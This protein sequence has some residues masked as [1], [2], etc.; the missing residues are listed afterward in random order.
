[1]K[2]S[3]VISLFLAFAVIVGCFAGC[4][5]NPQVQA[6]ADEIREDVVKVL[7]EK[8]I[9]DYTIADKLK[10][11]TN[12]K[13]YL[14][15]D[16]P[17]LEGMDEQSKVVLLNSLCDQSDGFFMDDSGETSDWTMI[18]V[19]VTSHD[20]TYAAYD[21]YVYY[22]NGETVV[23]NKKS[24]TDSSNYDKDDP[25]YSNNDYNNDGNLDVNEFQGAVGDYMDQNGY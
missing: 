8:G 10:K 21:N 9:T 3:K 1:M 14:N 11:E 16:I 7:S 13:Y 23:V 24:N 4:G 22:K 17:S 19:E 15:V 5:T 25:Y 20:N 2:K 12:N 6:C 18:F